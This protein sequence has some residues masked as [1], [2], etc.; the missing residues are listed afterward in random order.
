METMKQVS[1]PPR[2]HEFLEMEWWPKDELVAYA[3]GKP[4]VL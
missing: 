2:V 1:T 3:L 4:V